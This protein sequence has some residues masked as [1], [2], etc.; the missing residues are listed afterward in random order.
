MLVLRINND[1][2]VNVEGRLVN[3]SKVESHN[4]HIHIEH[5]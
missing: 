2:V 1:Y 3:M 4:V 5:A